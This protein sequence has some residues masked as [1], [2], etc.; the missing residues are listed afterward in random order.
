MSRLCRCMAV[1]LVVGVVTSLQAATHY[2][3]RNGQTPVADYTSWGTAASNIQDAVGVAGAGG[4]VLVSNGL[5]TVSSQIVVGDLTVRSFND[6]SV[7]RDGTIL[8]RGSSPVGAGR[9]PQ[10]VIADIEALAVL[11]LGEASLTRSD[12]IGVGVGAPGPLSPQTGRIIRAANLPGWENVSLRDSLGERLQKPV[13]VD[14]DGN[15]AA[16]GE[17]WVGA[18]RDVE[19]LVMF[20]LGTGVGAGVILGG[21]VLH[22]HFENAAELGHMIVVAEGLP[23]PCGQRGCLEQYASAAS[24]ARRARTAVEGGEASVLSAA[25]QAG[26][27]V[28]AKDVVAGARTGDALC[29]RLW[30]EVCLYLAIA[31]I[32]V[33]HAYNPARI[34]L[35]GGMSEATDFLLDPLRV[36]V[37]RQK[38]SLHDDLPTIALAS[39]GYDAGVIGAAGLAWQRQNNHGVKAQVSGG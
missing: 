20:T 13:T 1:G 8:A 2:V 16:F 38:W 32:N 31:C 12:L 17:C 34:V 39:L 9:G 19:D 21:Q 18:G 27:Q 4:L 14:N 29:R 26:Q 3:A 30:D 25:I 11:L 6:G 22:G 15:A 36:H 5:Y 7:D 10:P 24:V 37:E 28:G 23:C 33:Q 35:G